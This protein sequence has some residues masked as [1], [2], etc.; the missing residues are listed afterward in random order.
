MVDS[1]AAF[2]A[3]HPGSGEVHP[4]PAE[5][6]LRKLLKTRSELFRGTCCES[7]EGVRFPTEGLTSR[8]VPGNFLGS[9]GNFLGSLGSSGLL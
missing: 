5:K 7:S 9:S 8:E 4:C 1:R 3:K 6:P 2:R